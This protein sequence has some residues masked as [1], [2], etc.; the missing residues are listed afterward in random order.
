MQVFSSM[1]AELQSRGQIINLKFS[2]SHDALLST[3]HAYCFAFAF[4]HL[5]IL[6]TYLSS[7]LFLLNLYKFSLFLFSHSPLM[8]SADIDF[9][10]IVSTDHWV[11][12]FLTNFF[13]L[14][15]YRVG[16]RKYYTKQTHEY[17]GDSKS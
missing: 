15:M 5:F 9:I 16:I 1:K 7:F 12:I 6:S 13:C 2:P 11:L 14:Y 10:F 3:P 8:T 17:I 4:A